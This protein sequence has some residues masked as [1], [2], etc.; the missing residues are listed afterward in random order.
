MAAA[1]GGG[2]TAVAGGPAGGDCEGSDAVIEVRRNLLP[3]PRNPAYR[4]LR[5]QL[6]AC[7][8]L[9]TV[10]AIS[11]VCTRQVTHL[12]SKEDAAGLIGTPIQAIVGSWA[13][14]FAWG[15]RL[16]NL[17]SQLGALRES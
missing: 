7:P 12:V 14:A 16:Y 1:C 5:G 2:T 11:C 6:G 9:S 3:L 17:G 10:C 15:A 8:A 13:N 4:H